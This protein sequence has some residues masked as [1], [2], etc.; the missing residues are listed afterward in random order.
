M[1]QQLEWSD[2]EDKTTMINMLRFLMGKVDNVMEVDRWKL[3]KRIKRECQNSCYCNSCEKCLWWGPQELWPVLGKNQ[4]PW[5]TAN[6]DFPK[7][8]ANRKKMK[9][10]G[11]E[12]PKT[13]K[14]FQNTWHRRNW[15]ARSGSKRKKSRKNIWKMMTE[16]SKLLIGPESDTQK[17][18]RTASYLM[19]YKFQLKKR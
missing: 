4:W 3:W 7:W 16:I 15:N 6:K 11:V 17:A 2:R 9:K 18:H 8:T 10:C 5:R 19:A 1:T 13:V 14:Q 12:H